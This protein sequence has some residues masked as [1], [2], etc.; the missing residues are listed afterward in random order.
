MNKYF[1]GSP[2]G[3]PSHPAIISGG[4]GE[5]PPLAA[6]SRAV[7]LAITTYALL[8]ITPASLQAEEGGSGHYLPGSISSFID[9]VPPDETIAVRYNFLSYS[10]GRKFGEP[11]PIA[12]VTA[13]NAEADS[14]AHGLTLLWR[15]AWNPGENLSY[16]VN[17]TIP[18]IT[19]DVEADI[20]TVNGVTIRNSD[21]VDGLGDIVLMPVMLNYTVNKD[22]SINGRLGIYLPTGDYEVGRLA[23]AGKNYT[24]YEPLIGAVYLGHENGREASLY[25][26][27]D[28]NTENEDTDY[29]TGTQV[30]LDG[31]LAQHLP[32]A[33]GLVG[34]GVNGYWYEQ[35]DGD[36]G[37]G[38][39]LGAFKGRTVGLGPVLSYVQGDMA[40]ELKWV[41]ET[42]VKDRL[43]GDFIWLKV[44]KKF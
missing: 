35:V 26:G 14:M 25:F 21:S 22:L 24:T 41:H 37:T 11:L 32:V 10:G 4:R 20:T 18:Y 23:N 7:A 6:S 30:H 40:A 5:W 1:R 9:G 39:K 38:A 31:T 8:S 33:G 27:A 16:A 19:L 43:E 2:G 3:S 17:A 34:V 13:I 29:E 12:G 44:A 15:P 36:S 28:F 42:E